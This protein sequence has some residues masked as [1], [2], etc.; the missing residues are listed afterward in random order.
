MM[1]SGRD[2]RKKVRQ[3]FVEEENKKKCGQRQAK[4]C[5]PVGKVQFSA[6]GFQLLA[7]YPI[8]SYSVESM[9]VAR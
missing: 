9:M 8:R 5:D 2:V 4:E 3:W 1:G 7:G 6:C